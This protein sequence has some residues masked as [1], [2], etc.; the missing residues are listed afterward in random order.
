MIPC[1]EENHRKSRLLYTDFVIRDILQSFS[2][3][4]GNVYNGLKT[5]DLVTQK[6]N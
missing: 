2:G 5:G 3:E 6:C 1:M 4:P